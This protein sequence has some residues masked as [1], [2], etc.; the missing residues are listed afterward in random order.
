MSA[1]TQSNIQ[2][3]IG[4]LQTLREQWSGVESIDAERDK[5]Q[6]K[7]DGVKQNIV[8]MRGEFNEVKR[9][10]DQILAKAHEAQAELQRME[11]EIKKRKGELGK[12]NAELAKIPDKLRGFDKFV[13]DLRHESDKLSQINSGLNAI[14]VQ[15]GA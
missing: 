6:A 14:R 15:V 1:Q 9:A 3:A 11:A 13:E 10:H 8:A 5:A 7:L 12:I 2:R 4:D